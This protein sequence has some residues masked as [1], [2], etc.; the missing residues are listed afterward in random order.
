[1]SIIRD[2]KLY[3]RI[4]S[5]GKGLT[6]ES[7]PIQVYGFKDGTSNFVKLIHL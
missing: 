7:V 4:N 5:D 1:M 2:Q 6:K 3:N